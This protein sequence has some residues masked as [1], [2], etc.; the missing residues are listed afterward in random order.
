MA[1]PIGVWRHSYPGIVLGGITLLLHL[2]VNSRYGIF[3][4]ELYFMVCGQHP[5]MGY[6]D[7]PPLVPLIA[8]ISHSW[9]GTALLPLRLIPALAMA[10]T[11]GLTAEFARALGGGRFAQWLSGLTVLLG[12]D[13]L[14]DGL[15]LLTDMM[16]PLTWLGCSWCLLRLAQTGNQRWWLGFGAVAGISLLSKYL[17]LFFLA[18]LAVGVILTPLRRSLLQ[19]WI[20][21]GAAI[22]LGIA[23][24]SLIW[25][26]MHGWP[27]LELSKTAVNG[28]N[29]ALTPLEFFGQQVLFVG[30]AAAPVWLAGL[31]RFSTKPRLAELRAFPIAYAV[32]AT[33]FLALHGKAYYIVPIYPALLAGGAVAIE[34]W[35]AWKPLRGAVLAAVAVIGVLLAPLALPILPP[36]KYASYAASLGI[37]SGAASSERGQQGTL[38]PQLAGMF[39]WPEMAAKVS[40]V[41]HALPPNERARAVF[42]GRDYGEAAA[43]EIY[44]PALHGP[45]VVAGNNNYY[46]W[47]PKYF[48]GSVVI[49]LDGDVT[50]LM[51]NYESIQ[52]VGRIDSPFAQSWEAHMAIYVLRKPRASLRKLWPHLKHYE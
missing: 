20:Y 51:R 29:L 50:P 34:E 17:I 23:A 33:L 15:L 11:V 38:P 35:F 42:Y 28:K 24:P 48:D 14:V 8:G 4:D 10:L 6:V 36:E 22:A 5:A 27:F 32:M 9:F 19:R 45:P 37:P 43:L 49:V 52:V 47:G 12:G 13:F 2:L 16:Q 46:L 44:G 3:S 25:Q 21:L 30:P 1:G 39:G 26:A 7:Q 41:Y 18:G 31:W 40:A